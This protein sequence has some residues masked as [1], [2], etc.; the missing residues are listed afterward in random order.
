MR[1]RVI[2]GLR[3]VADLLLPRVCI[4]CGRKLELDENHICR[5]CLDDIPLTRFHLLSHNPMAD[6]FNEII[7]KHLEALWDSEGAESHHFERYVYA[8]A[9]FFYSSGAGYRHIPHQIKYHGNLSAGR[10]FGNMLG[11]EVA[12]TPWLQGIDIV[13]PVPLHWRRKW[14]RGYNQAEIIGE[15]VASVIGASLRTDILKRKRHTKTQTKLEI[16]EKSANV[17]GAFEAH[18]TDIEGIR[19][20]LLIDD[21]FTTG[22]T[23]FACFSALREVFPPSVR[24][25]IAT[26]AFVGGA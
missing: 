15:Q 2:R 18:E 14:T 11:R 8:T 25:S 6:R 9:L 17:K 21:V 13:I 4:V 22:N 7:Q 5:D 12:L 20:V 10:Y 26:L 19:H 24:I 23:L 3:A 16:S 1:G